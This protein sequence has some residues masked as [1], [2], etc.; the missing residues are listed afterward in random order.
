MAGPHRH[1]IG[2]P[3]RIRTCDPGIRNPVLYPTELRARPERDITATTSRPQGWPRRTVLLALAGASTLPGKAIAAPQPSTVREVSSSCRLSLAD[4]TEARLAGVLVPQSPGAG[5]AIAARAKTLMEHLALG[6]QVALEMLGTDRQGCPLVMARTSAGTWLQGELVGAGLAWVWPEGSDEETPLL[7]EL[8]A[9]ARGRKVG[10]WSSAMLGEQS[11][12][13]VRLF[14]PRFVVV[15]GRVRSVGKGRRW[16]YLNF[17][18]DWRH[19]LT[20]RLDRSERSRPWPAAVDPA[21][22]A[23]RLVRVRGWVF[24]WDGPMIELDRKGQ[25]EIVE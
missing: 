7:Q 20:A 1:P 25:L 24:S 22:L 3:D 11:A 16:L 9:D 12:D 10:L 5:G 14:P 19:D 18:D 17:G 4:G 21:T 13:Q 6:Q 15:V 8:E 23:G 2:A